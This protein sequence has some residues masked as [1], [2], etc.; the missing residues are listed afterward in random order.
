[1][2]FVDQL[3]Q[4]FR[5]DRVVAHEGRNDP[6]SQLD[7]L[8]LGPVIHRFHPSKRSRSASA[9]AK[10]STYEVK[11]KA[12]VVYLQQPKA[13]PNM[14]PALIAS[15]CFAPGNLCRR[16]SLDIIPM[17]MSMW[18]AQILLKSL[19]VARHFQPCAK[20]TIADD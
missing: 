14:I 19:T 17:V 20:C 1:M 13:K 6:S 4:I 16:A 8:R 18:C 15:E 12:T 11:L 2:G 10:P 5:T 9:D 7:Q 3:R